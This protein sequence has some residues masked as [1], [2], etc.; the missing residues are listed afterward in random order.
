MVSAARAAMDVSRLK[1]VTLH[2]QPPLPDYLAAMQ[3]ANAEAGRRLGESMLLSWFD[4]DF[5]ASQHVSECHAD[6]AVPGYPVEY[7]LHA[8]A[9]C[10]T[11]AIVYKATM[12]GIAIESI[13]S[14]L[15]GDMDAR[16]FLDLSAEQRTGCQRI[17]AT[18]KV[19]ANATSEEIRELAEY[20]PV[21]DVVTRGT[22]VSTQVQM[23]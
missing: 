20:S 23:I 16:N 12:R 21:F 18:F 6:S 17:R 11:S 22:P 14:T 5:E 13:E 7:L 8:L 19:K 15:D 10:L 9:A 4:R 3:L 2:P 1:V